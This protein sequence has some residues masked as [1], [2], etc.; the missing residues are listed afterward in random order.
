MVVVMTG[1][2]GGGG[3][4]A[5]GDHLMNSR[6]IPLAEST[7]SLPANPDGVAMLESRLEQSTA[8]PRPESVPP[9]PE[10]AQQISGKTIVLESNAVGLQSITLDFPGEAEAALRLT[11]IDGN[12]IMWPIGLDKVHRFTVF[13]HGLTMGFM[14]EWESDNVFVVHRDVIGGYERERL[15]ATFEED[16]ITI[17][18]HNLTPGGGGSVALAGRF[19]E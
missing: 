15:D 8:A 10:I 14:G 17:Q 5:W 19:E 18:I 4:G 1:S 3:A 11:F 13:E 6:I 9:L 12:Q 16:Q 7:T 2:T